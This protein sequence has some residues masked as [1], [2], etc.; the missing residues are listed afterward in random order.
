[1]PAVIWLHACMWMICVLYSN[2]VSD[3]VAFMQQ[4]NL[5]V[6]KK[7]ND[8]FQMTFGVLN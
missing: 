2:A 1:M 4:F 5:Q 3:Y 8:Y 7:P 6:Y